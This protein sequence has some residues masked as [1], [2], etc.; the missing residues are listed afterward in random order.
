MAKGVEPQLEQVRRL[1]QARRS[2]ERRARGDDGDKRAGR[3]A[4]F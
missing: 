4:C 1:A 2:G 3:F